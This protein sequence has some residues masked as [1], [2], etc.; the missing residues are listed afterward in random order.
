MHVRRSNA[1]GYFGASVCAMDG[2]RCALIAEVSRQHHLPLLVSAAPVHRT[3]EPDDVDGCAYKH[4][5]H[6]WQ[7][8]KLD[9]LGYRGCHVGRLLLRCGVQAGR[10]FCSTGA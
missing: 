8:D 4:G 1:I 3:R 7:Y 2:A 9:P 5:Q 6:E 10:D